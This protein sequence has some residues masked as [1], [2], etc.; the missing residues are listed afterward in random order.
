MAILLP[1]N[2]DFEKLTYSPVKTLDSGAKSI[3]ISYDNKPLIIQ[4]PRMYAPFG[5]SKFDKGTEI[6]END[7]YSLQLAFKELDTN[8]SVKKFFDM[9]IKFDEKLIDDGVKESKNW[10][11]KTYVKDVLKELFTNSI[12]FSKEKETG[13]ITN[14]YPPNFRLNIPTVNGKI[15]PDCYDITKEKI[16]LDTIK[17]GSTVSAIIKCSGIWMAGS[18]FGCSWK[19]MQLLVNEPTNFNGY[20]FNDDEDEQEDDKKVS[21]VA[22]KYVE[23]SDDEEVPEE[24]PK[25]PEEDPKIPEEDD[26]DIPDEAVDRTVAE[27]A[28]TKPVAKT[29]RKKK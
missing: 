19:V 20:S 5:M 26:V 11:K 25:V 22:Q 28:V 2:V 12:T 9:L 15:K 17:K 18:K 29:T 24:D 1:K 7:K 27:E 14:K 23:S 16:E 8:P 13:E 3:Y 10:F 21:S 4:T 6:L